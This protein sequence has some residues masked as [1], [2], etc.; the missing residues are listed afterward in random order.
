MIKFDRHIFKQLFTIT[1]FVLFV[2]I[3]IFVLI[4]FSENSDEFAENG[5][6]MAEIWSSIISITCQK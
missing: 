6:G 2:L 4:D 5:A 3:C 1:V